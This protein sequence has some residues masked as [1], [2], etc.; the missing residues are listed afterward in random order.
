MIQ[1][2]QLKS[3]VAK[4]PKLPHVTKKSK[5]FTHS[6]VVVAISAL[7]PFL[8]ID[9]SPRSVPFIKNF[10]PAAPSKQLK[11][12]G[13]C[14]DKWNENDNLRTMNR[15]FESL[16][17]EFI[18]DTENRDFDIIWS[19]EDE[20]ELVYVKMKQLKQHQKVNHFP[21]NEVL[22]TKSN[23]NMYNANLRYILPSFLM[24]YDRKVLDDYMKKYPDTR[25]VRKNIYNRGVM[26][27][28]PKDINDSDPDDFFQVFLDK[29]L[30]ID[31]HAFDMGIFVLITSIEP[32]RI[33]KF[34]HEVLLRFCAKKYH[35]FD[36]AELGRYVVQEG[37]KSVYEMKGF[38]E[39]YKKYSMTVKDLLERRMRGRGYDVDDLWKQVDDAIVKVIGNSVEYMLDEAKKDNRSMHNYFELVRFDFMINEY[40]NVYVMEVNMSPNM[41]PAEARFEENSKLYEPMIHS[42]VQ[43]VGGASHHEFMSRLNLGGIIDNKIN[44]CF[45]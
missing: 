11:Y 39:E 25:Y 27:V 17:F 45:F 20:P 29:P 4:V 42:T 13:I 12:M 40:G 21:G 35:P 10:I 15:V 5:I 41:T 16:N 23:M 2:S 44:F 34:D 26:I 19:I 14:L 33:Y 1:K 8:L 24:P 6:R 7:L 38:G 36:A 28:E 22:V 37:H 43:M 30:L 9:I 3:N 18:N 31:G 32:L